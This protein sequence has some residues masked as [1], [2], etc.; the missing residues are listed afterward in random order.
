MDIETLKN[1]G[2]I[3]ATVAV[4]AG[5]IAYVFDKVI[6]RRKSDKIEEITFA[7]G[8]AKFWKD[9]AEG[10]KVMMAEKDKS[11]D[12]KYIQL[13]KELAEIRGQ[14]IEKEKQNKE[15][16]AI[17]QDR[18]PETKEFMKFMIQAT[19][20][21]TESHKEIV[22]ILREIHTMSKAEHDRDFKVEATV[23]KT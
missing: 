11:N 20:N 8:A 6:H 14:L 9:Q 1:L 22:S 15:Y 2:W 3:V 5:S 21:Q 18:D 16:L 10:Y 4:V 19:K 13:T 12:E 7:D 17:L 23:T